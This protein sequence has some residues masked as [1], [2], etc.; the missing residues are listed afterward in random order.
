MTVNRPLAR[1]TLAGLV[2]VA[3]AATGLNSLKPIHMDDPAYLAFAQ[4][5]RREPSR[6]YGF[7]MAW[8]SQ[9][10]PA[11]QILAPPIFLYYLALCLNL[12]T[13][14]FIW[15]LMLFPWVL[16]LTISLSVIER[17]VTGSTSCWSIGAFILGP[18]VLPGM[19]L[20]LDLPALALSSAGWALTMTSLRQVRFL[21]LFS[22]GLIFGLAFETKYTAVVPLVVAIVAVLV[23]PERIVAFQRRFAGA[24]LLGLAAMIVVLGIEFWIAYQHGVSH[25][26]TN[27]GASRIPW[28]IRWQF[29]IVGMTYLGVAVIGFLPSLL[30]TLRQY[31]VY[32]SSF[33]TFA[34]WLPFAT[35]SLLIIHGFRVSWHGQVLAMF[36]SLV[37]SMSVVRLFLGFQTKGTRLEN[38]ASCLSGR[39]KWVLFADMVLECGFVAAASPFLAMRRFMG[40][41]IPIWLSCGIG[42]FPTHYRVIFSLPSIVLGFAIWR[43][44]LIDASAMHDAARRLV[45]K[46]PRDKPL[47]YLGGWGWGY[48]AEK[49]G[50]LPLIPNRTAVSPGDLIAVPASMGSSVPLLATRLPLFGK[51]TIPNDEPKSRIRLTG[52]YAGTEPLGIRHGPD[53][54]VDLLEVTP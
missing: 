15:H 54:T 20:M 47:Y 48:A 2:L 53:F 4:Q 9:W 29:P 34:I 17:T 19:N 46:I 41:V 23:V 52:Y 13:D 18:A 35:L 25:F 36:G 30:A 6:P 40:L 31:G 32:R 8:D 37:L 38:S 11:M 39:L 14:P 50:M 43:L 33:M 44:D 16:L 10:K 24:F 5:I 42:T 49:V 22:A 27:R 21:S 28:S 1:S 7:A 12:S 51:V 3:V 45:T 26:W